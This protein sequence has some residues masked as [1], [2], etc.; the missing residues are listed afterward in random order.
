MFLLL[1]LVAGIGSSDGVEASKAAV[2][3]KNTQGV[4]K[5]WAEWR[6]ADAQAN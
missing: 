3:A 6:E 2:A 1:R 5:G 4:V